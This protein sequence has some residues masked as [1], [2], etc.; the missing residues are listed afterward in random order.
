M[1]S[2]KFLLLMG[3]AQVDPILSIFADGTDGFYFDGSKT[4]RTFQ[5]QVNTAADDAAES[6]GLALEGSKWSGASLSARTRAA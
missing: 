6:I 4:D 1:L 3:T 2:R 5:D